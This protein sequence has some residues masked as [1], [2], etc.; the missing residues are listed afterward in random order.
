MSFLVRVYLGQLNF[1]EFLLY[2]NQFSHWCMPWYF[3]SIA[4]WWYTSRNRE[5]TK[6]MGEGARVV[7]SNKFAGQETWISCNRV[8]IVFVPLL[9]ER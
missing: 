3:C 9:L 4:T 5:A 6:G 2:E 7:P 1:A 8:L